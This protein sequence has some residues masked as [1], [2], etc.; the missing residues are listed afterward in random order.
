MDRG[1]RGGQR[2]SNDPFEGGREEGR[3]TTVARSVWEK[4]VF[5]QTHIYAWL[6]CK[7]HVF[8]G[9]VNVEMFKKCPVTF[10]SDKP[11]PLSSSCTK[12]FSPEFINFVYLLF[13]SSCLFCFC[14]C[15]FNCFSALRR[16]TA[17]D[18]GKIK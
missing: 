11:L 9:Q 5:V 4:F 8:N 13:F 1:C 12:Y 6:T 15:S 14:Y 3:E 10:I 18:G 16:N 2:R 17:T 7:E